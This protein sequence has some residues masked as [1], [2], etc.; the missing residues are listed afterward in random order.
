MDSNQLDELNTYWMQ[1]VTAWKSSGMPQSTFCQKHDLIYHRFIYWK[2]KFEGLSQPLPV[3]AKK[4]EF[5]KVHPAPSGFHRD[6]GLA[7]SLP[8]GMMLKGLSDSNLSLAC[9]LIKQLS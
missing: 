5:V 6:S 7:L 3:A 2:L 8:N 9:Q 1:Q 4:S